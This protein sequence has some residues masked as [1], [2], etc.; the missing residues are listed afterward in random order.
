[1]VAIGSSLPFLVMI[2]FHDERED[3]HCV[4]ADVVLKAFSV[5]AFSSSERS[6]S[7]VISIGAND[8]IVDASLICS[9]EVAGHWGRLRS[10]FEKSVAEETFS[11]LLSNIFKFEE[12]CQVGEIKRRASDFIDDLSGVQIHVSVS[13]KKQML[14]ERRGA[15]FQSVC[16]RSHF[17]NIAYNPSIKLKV[18]EFV[19]AGMRLYSSKYR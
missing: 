3:L 17:D 12:S 10:I 16:M 9:S 8:F 14:A 6:A 1:M 15:I 5:H 11:I 7:G 4:L 18:S 19:A 2:P 13:S